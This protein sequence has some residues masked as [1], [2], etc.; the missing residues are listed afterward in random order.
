MTLGLVLLLVSLS[1]PAWNGLM[2]AGN[3][4]AATSRVMDTL[5]HARSEA[6][7]SGRE[8]WV[9]MR[10]AGK[11]GAASLRMVAGG[12]KGAVPLGPWTPLPAGTDFLGGRGAIPDEPPPA[13]VLAA[14][15]GSG[16]PGGVSPGSVMFRPS[17]EIGRP[18]PGG[19]SLSV[20]FVSG[21]RETIVTL[22]RGT[23]RAGCPKTS[24]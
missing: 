20:P 15:G 7:A 19:N 5:E 23:G 8:V 3:R 13:E 1:F 18:L 2:R 22:S 4:R 14:A 12:R 6:I 10:P 11:E 21:G 16:K 17:G 9:L 24:S